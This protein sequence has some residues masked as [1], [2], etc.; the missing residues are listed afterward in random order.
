[1]KKILLCLLIPIYSL[2]Q[3]VPDIKKISAFIYIKDSIGKPMIP[4][5]TCFF[6]NFSKD[7]IPVNYKHYIV[8]AKHV[9]IDTNG[10]VY[11][12]IF[13]KANKRNGRWQVDTIPIFTKSSK[14]NI[15]FH[16]DAT[17]DLAVVAY[18]PSKDLDIVFLDPSHIKSKED[19]S[20]Q[21]IVEGTET[22][23]SGLFWQHPGTIKIQP[24]VRFGKIALIP[25]ERIET[26]NGLSEIILI[27]SNSFGG[28]SGAPVYFNVG[29]GQQGMFLLGGIMN[30]A[31]NDYLKWQKN[32]KYLNLPEYQYNNGIA[33]ITPAYLLFDLLYFEPSIK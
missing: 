32:G 9:L 13:I 11:D 14:R 30:G 1:M 19:F 28:N 2:G 12:T 25:D 17:V 22:I 6:I 3:T 26:P 27:E 21:G 20:Q 7:N 5:G 33:F 8:T 29:G 15:F 18:S 31:F 23:F 16:S 4:N 24:I 10:H